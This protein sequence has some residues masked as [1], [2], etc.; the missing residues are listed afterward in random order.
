MRSAL[1]G[2]LLLLLALPAG[3]QIYKSLD[4]N[5]NPVFSSQPPAG[6][7]HQALIYVIF[8]FTIWS[9]LRFAQRGATSAIVLV[10]GI[11]IWG[12]V[13]GVLDHSEK[14]D[15]T[16]STLLLELLQREYLKAS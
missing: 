10:S 4:A 16:V 14:D 7:F 6:V 1:P 8:P 2:L 3:A 12:T 11:A 5:G 13:Q 15:L 9:A